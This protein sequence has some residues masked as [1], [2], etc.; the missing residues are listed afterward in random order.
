MLA[1][2][3]TMM[4]TMIDK[5]VRPFFTPRFV[6]FAAVGAS[7]VM[8]NL[9]SLALLKSVGLQ[10]NMA[11]ALAI[12][13]SILSNFLIN[14]AWTF[15]DKREDAASF[16]GQALRFH[17]VCLI[18]AG[19]QLLVFVIMNMVWLLTMF[20]IDAVTRYHMAA[21]S[22]TERWLWRPFVEPPAVGDWVY[23]SQLMGIACGTFWN[24]L[25]NFYWTFA[26]RHQLVREIQSGEDHGT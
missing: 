23:V 19:I 9:G 12:E 11:A 2:M 24:Y 15:R 6:K 3:G 14:Y 17:L 22:W 1:I 20:D 4:G 18:G 16:L 21:D 8:V 26:A 7:G 25:L 5:L 13:I 10:I